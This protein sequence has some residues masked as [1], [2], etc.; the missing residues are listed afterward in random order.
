[1]ALICNATSQNR[2]NDLIGRLAE[3]WNHAGAA[4]AK[5]NR[6]ESK[7]ISPYWDVLVLME[8]NLVN[9]HHHMGYQILNLLFYI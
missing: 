4:S 1:M 3:R 7:E 6:L 2:A 9:L 8:S 5:A